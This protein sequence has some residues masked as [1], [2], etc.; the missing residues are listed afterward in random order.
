[1]Q[2]S[3]AIAVRF[4]HPTFCATLLKLELLVGLVKGVVP[5][6]AI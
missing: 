5:E 6:T 2:S 1:M 4:A 3:S